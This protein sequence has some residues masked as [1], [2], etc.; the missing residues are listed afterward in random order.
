V[1]VA[2]AVVVGDAATVTVGT[3]T[4]GSAEVMPPGSRMSAR[5]VPARPRLTRRSRAVTPPNLLRSVVLFTA[6]R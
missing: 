6:T 1:A 3:E 4:V 2:S 5:A